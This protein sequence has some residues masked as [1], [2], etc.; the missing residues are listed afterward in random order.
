[1]GLAI[2]SLFDPPSRTEEE[3][4]C[5]LLHAPPP[6]PRNAK[7]RRAAFADGRPVR[8]DRDPQ[9]ELRTA[10]SWLF[11]PKIFEISILRKYM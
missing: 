7:V 6:R 4:C 1:M 5:L 2:W 9:Q 10:R 8:L 3:R 11:P